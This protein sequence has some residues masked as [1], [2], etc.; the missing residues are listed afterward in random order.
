MARSGGFIEVGIAH[1]TVVM[2]GLAA[3]PTHET[4]TVCIGWRSL[5]AEAKLT[6]VFTDIYVTYC[7]NCEPFQTYFSFALKYN[8]VRSRLSIVDKG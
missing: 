3:F 6:F 1:A 4:S 2:F 8:S 7:I 5:Y